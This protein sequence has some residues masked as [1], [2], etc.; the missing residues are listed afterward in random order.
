METIKKNENQDIVSMGTNSALL[1]RQV[2]ENGYQVMA[3]HLMALAQAVDC[4]GIADGLSSA[5]RRL[6]DEVRALVPVFIEDTPKYREIA[7]LEHYL[8][9]TN[10]RL[11]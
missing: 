2:I 3:I 10:L 11:L 4:L 1:C 9:T 8:R 7:R 6:Y 5:T